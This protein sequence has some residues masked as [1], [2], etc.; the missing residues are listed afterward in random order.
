MAKTVGSSLTAAMANTSSWA[1]ERWALSIEARRP[2]V[3][4]ARRMYGGTIEQTP[5]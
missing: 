5:C 3:D 1:N 2:C 4:S